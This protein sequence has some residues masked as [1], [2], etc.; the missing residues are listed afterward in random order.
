VTSRAQIDPVPRVPSADSGHT[1]FGSAVRLVIAP[2]VL[3][4][5]GFF[6]VDFLLSGV[7]TWPRTT[8]VLVLTITLTVLAYEFVYKEQRLRYPIP[9]DVRPLKAVLYSCAIPYA[10][11]A[12]ALIGLARLI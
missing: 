2:L 12:L 11:G 4:S 6:T 10:V 5:G 8:R 9:S 3:C 7:Y 1:R